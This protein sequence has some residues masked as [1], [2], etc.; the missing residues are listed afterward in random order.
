[1]TFDVDD[2]KD[3]EEFK[4]KNNYTM[5]EALNFLMDRLDELKKR[6]ADL[7]KKN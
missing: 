1:M 4:T 2:Y 7:L 3:F 5:A 6:E